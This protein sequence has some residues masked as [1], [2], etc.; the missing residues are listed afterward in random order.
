MSYS[1]TAPFDPKEYGPSTLSTTL[2]RLLGNKF[3]L[4]SKTYKLVKLSNGA[5]ADVRKKVLVWVSRANNTV[6]LCTA[7]TDRTAGIGVADMQLSSIP[8]GSYLLIQVGKGDR[9]VVT[10]GDDH[11]ANPIGSTNL[12]AIPDDDADT[13]KAV[14]TLLPTM[15]QQPF[16]R[17][18]SGTAADNAEITVELLELDSVSAL[19]GG[20]YKKGLVTGAAAAGACTFTG[21]AVGD[22]VVAAFLIADESDNL[23]KGE[24]TATTVPSATIFESVITVVNQIQ[25]TSASDLSDNKYFVELA[26]AN[27]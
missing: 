7:K 13:G 5:D 6:K 8:D 23:T 12:L 1:F 10:H 15:G 2:D 4:G 21:A 17:Y 24:G 9:V 20:A 11:S 19:P 27:A 14:G 3:L 18:I 25:Q 26:P 16:G 22:R